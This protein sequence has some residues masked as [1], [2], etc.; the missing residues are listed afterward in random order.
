MPSI[1]RTDGNYMKPKPEISAVKHKNPIIHARE[2]LSCAMRDPTLAKQAATS[3]TRTGSGGQPV[4]GVTKAWLM[5]AE[6]RS[7]QK[8]LL[9]SPLTAGHVLHFIVLPSPQDCS[10]Y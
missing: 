4:L 1:A 9:P 5:V 7:P 2:R 8:P 3:C 6:Q 10:S